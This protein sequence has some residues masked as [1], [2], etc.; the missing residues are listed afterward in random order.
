M[1]CSKISPVCAAPDRSE[2][3]DR[4]E[5]Q[6]RCVPA[7]QEEGL[8]AED[9]EQEGPDAEVAIHD[10]E[11]AGLDDH[12]IQQGPLL[13]VGVLLQDDVEDQATDR[14]VDRQR[15]ARQGAEQVERNSVMRWS[16]PVRT[17]PSRIRAAY[18]GIGSGRSPPAA[19]IRSPSPLR[20]S[21][22]R[23]RR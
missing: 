1:G 9:S 13:G 22:G 14:L 10:P 17:L 2:R 4:L 20:R 11:L 21:R 8:G 19:A 16:V 12:L 5:R 3:L 7:D 15:L 23:W 18:P 6:G